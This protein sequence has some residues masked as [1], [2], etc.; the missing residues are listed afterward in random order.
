MDIFFDGTWLPLTFALLMVVAVFVYAVLDGYDIGVGLLLRGAGAD[1][2]DIMIASIGPFW[3]AN[4]TWLVLAVGIL[5]IAFPEANGLVLTNLYLPVA[6][7]LVGLTLRGV[8]FDF[9][10]KAKI[11]QK[12]RWDD[13]FFAGSFLMAVSQGYMVA[14][15]VLGF[16]KG[17]GAACFSLAVGLCVAAAYGLIGA[18]WLIMKTEKEL[19]KKAVCWA[20]RCLYG[21][22]AG[23]VLVGVATPLASERV[24]E[25]WTTA[26]GAY[27]L[28][29]LPLGLAC[30]I[31]LAAHV[32]R[33]LPAK[34]DAGC[35]H[36]F[37]LT[38]G[39]YLLCLIGLAY[40]FYPYIVP[41]QLKI[42]EAAAAPESLMFILIGAL[43]V[44][45]FLIG[46]TLYAYKI[47]HGKT[48]EVAY[49]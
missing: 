42:V 32:L 10:A 40:S 14:S 31:G 29:L 43:I 47:F 27:F 2:R 35:W 45:P 23:I 13:L 28:S 39:I 33:R 24:F 19:Q 3:D 11:E 9:R 26:P 34:S 16:E 44:L 8:S 36:P 17:I 25:R 49:Y 1:E 30:L 12:P 46:Y 15:Y 21:T 6:F 7:M 38:V 5:L 4:E 18:S 48:R 37:A 20:R 41:G 22:A